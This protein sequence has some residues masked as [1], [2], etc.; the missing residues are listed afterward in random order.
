M[1]STADWDNPFWTNKQHVAKT[2]A[3]NGYRVLY[4]ESVGLRAPTATAADFTRI[5]RRLR[6]ALRL[7]VSVIQTKQGGEV[8]VLSPLVIPLQR[9]RWVRRVNKTL[10]SLSVSW[11]RRWMKLR[12][13]W[14]WT[15]NPLTL[16]LLPVNSYKQLIYHCVDA[17]DAQP[18]MPKAELLQAE[19]GL[20]ERA[21]AIFCTSQALYERH[22]PR[23]VNTHYFGNVADAEHFEKARLADTPIPA[24]LLAIR[25]K[26]PILGFV[27]AISRYKQ[28]FA[29]LAE[30][31]RRQPEWQFVLIGK[32]GEGDPEDHASELEKC[33]NIHLLGPR[34]YDQL[35]AYLKAFDVCLL[36]TQ[37][38]E[39]TRNMF[40]MKFYEYLM[41]GKDV[42]AM[43]IDSLRGLD[44]YYYPAAD[45]D[46]FERQCKAVLNGAS[47][48][49]EPMTA[50]LN[51]CTY[52]ARNERMIE[53]IFRE[54]A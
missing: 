24:E 7:P 21:N 9:Y 11:A 30:L 39:Y 26:G 53:Q 31:A 54:K 38:N 18:G 22:A 33:P 19:A 16:Q 15:Y 41:A 6:K 46:A 35:P 23:N 28:D 3:E 34:R 47:K 52:K 1:F 14:L 4:I 27:G 5:F 17:I 32:V 20:A 51:A 13:D 49:G 44:D 2:L 37:R 45:V 12:P 25:E 50:H 36:P 10:L 48:Q 8:R 42:V 40:P 43:T 29:L